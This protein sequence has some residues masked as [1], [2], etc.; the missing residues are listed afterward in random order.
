VVAAVRALD[1]GERPLFTLVPA[2]GAAGG[3]LTVQ[4]RPGAYTLT[5]YVPDCGRVRYYDPQRDST[6]QVEIYNYELLRD[7]VDGRYVCPDLTR[8][9]G[10]V[11]YFWEYGALHPAVSWEEE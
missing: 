2:D 11:R 5:A 7:Y 4:G 10:I 9:L 8:V 1:G 6:E 3:Y